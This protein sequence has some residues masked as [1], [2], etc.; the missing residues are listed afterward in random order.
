LSIVI[1]SRQPYGF[2]ARWRI[3]SNG[4]QAT[5]LV[6]TTTRKKKKE[7]RKALQ[8]YGNSIAFSFSEFDPSHYGA[9]RDDLLK[10]SGN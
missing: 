5:D 2:P 9:K 4:Y 8:H 3:I 10:S 1:V 6:T 7:K